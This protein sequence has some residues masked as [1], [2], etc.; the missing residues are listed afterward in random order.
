MPPSTPPVEAN[1]G[2]DDGPR[3]PSKRPTKPIPTTPP[4]YQSIGEARGYDQTKRPLCVDMDNSFCVV[5]GM[6]IT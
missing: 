2:K 5:C 1:E 6:L 3:P 4:Q